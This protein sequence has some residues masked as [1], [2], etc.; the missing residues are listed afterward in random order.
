MKK[1]FKDQHF[2]S[3]LKNSGYLGAS[4]IVAAVAGIATLAFAARDL[5]VTLFGLLILIHSYAKAASG[6]SKFQSWQVIVRYGGQVLTG[7][8]TRDFKHATGFALGL[9]IASGLGGMVVAIALLPFI[10]GW[11]G[12]TPDL[13]GAA[14]L[15][16]T[17]LPTMGAMTP[18]G[19]LRA[20][21]R[22]DLLGWA[23][24]IYPIARA[25]LAGAAWA[26]DAPL[27]VYLAI[28]YV[29]DLAGDLLLWFFSLRE[30]KRR[31]LL[32]GIKPT[33]QTSGL[34][35]VWR[36]AIHINLT[37]SLMAAW[38]PIARLLVGALLGPASA[39]LY[40]TAASL[41]DSAQKPTELLGRAFY[42]EVMR[43]DHSTKRP[44]K[45]MLR[46][47]ALAGAVGVVAVTIVLLAGKQ[48]LALI[49]GEDFVPAYGA[50]AVLMVAPLLA[51]ISFPIPSM[52]YAADRPD[53]PFKARLAGVLTYFATVAPLSWEFEIIGAAAAFVIGYAVMTAILVAQVWSEYRKR[54]TL[55]MKE[56]PEAVAG[57]STFTT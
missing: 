37:S 11:F 53:G 44:W 47:M 23:G 46:G 31:H 39:A 41:S 56:P 52:L 8:G 10:G 49:F 21:D 36:F 16:C 24:A 26:S 27:L 9:D 57:E 7:G 48:L 3:L 18:Q 20:L 54:G 6:L 40:R 33:F 28:W 13:I 51:M 38:G 30:L 22:F 2:R 17:V 1:W 32:Q 42:P 55:K 5:G 12:L 14:M 19:V 35:G 25:I 43:M 45:L 50:L 15:Y 29:T 34:S 4:K